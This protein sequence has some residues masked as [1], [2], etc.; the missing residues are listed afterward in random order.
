MRRQVLGITTA[1]VF[2]LVAGAWRPLNSSDPLTLAPASKLWFDGE[3]TTKDWSCKATLLEAAVDAEGAGAVEAVLGGT[4][5]VKTVTFTVPVGKLDCDNGTM[6]NH[7]R[8]A[9]D[10]E[11]H[12]TIAFA[13][14]SYELATGSTVTGTLKGALTL[15]G[16]TLP[17]TLPV[18]FAAADGAL[19]VKG[20]YA[21][22]M[23]DW[24]VPPP[25]LFLGT[26]KVKEM[27][28]VRFDLLLK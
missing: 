26:M 10:A 21:L 18:E 8:K 9:L 6:N 16:V 5:A 19:R 22:K 3:S 25:K 23:T 13:L 4:K 2:L 7:M 11:T 15:R 14:E 20:V 17:I 27:V 12:Q 1:I 28:N 24:K